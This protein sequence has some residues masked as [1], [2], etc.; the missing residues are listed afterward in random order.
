MGKS[1][2][3]RDGKVQ[4]AYELNDRYTTE[5][6]RHGK[7]AEFWGYQ[8][9][10]CHLVFDVQMDFTR[11]A[12]FVANGSRMETPAWITYS[13]IIS[14]DSMRLAFLIAA[15][16]D[17]YVKACDIRNAYLNTPCHEKIWFRSSIECGKLNGKVMVVTW[18]LYGLRSSGTAWHRY[19]MRDGTLT[20]KIL[21]QLLC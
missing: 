4:V 7:A 6:I 11:K 15:L 12:Q 10:A 9:I 3:E 18:A 19:Y 8:E 17:L 5:E 21:S 1:H 16:N 13:S 2:Q 20:N 14:C